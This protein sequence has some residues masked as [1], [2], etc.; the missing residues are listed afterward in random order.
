MNTS[1]GIRSRSAAPLRPA[2]SPLHL[3]SFGAAVFHALHRRRLP[4]AGGAQQPGADS[5]RPVAVRA[6]AILLL[7]VLLL[8]MQSNHHARREP[9]R[10]VR[11]TPGARSGNGGAAVRSR[12]RCRAAALRR[13]HAE[14]SECPG[15]RGPGRQPRAVLPF[16]ECANPRFF[17]RARSA[18]CPR[19]RHRGVRR[20]WDSIAQASACRISIARCNWRSIASRAS[21]RRCAPSM[22]AALPDSAP[23]TW[24]SSMDC[25]ARLSRDFCHTLNTDRARATG[26]RGGL[27]LRA[28][29]ADCSRRR[30]RSTSANCPMPPSAL[31][32]LQLAIERLT[33][34]GYRYIGLDHFALPG[35]DLSVRARGRTACSAI[36]WVTPRMR[37]AISS[38]LAQAPSAIS[39]TVTARISAICRRGSPPWTRADCPSARGLVL[40]EDDVIRAE[41]IQQLMCRGVID[42]AQIEARHAHRFRPVLCRVAGTAP[43]AGGGRAGRHSMVRASSRPRAAG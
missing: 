36:S 25:R 19:W 32:L 21:R 14:L 18:Q 39:A 27:R 42:R 10:A 29:A 1:P 41:V 4:A 35:D 33:A 2:R 16:L 15:S 37:N 20:A 8:R 7:T 31:A 12:S 13:R 6:R 38:A 34:A 30:G 24:I 26:S 40:D 43:A 23:S 9:R 22:P 3:V 17:H 5:A 28:H 11:R